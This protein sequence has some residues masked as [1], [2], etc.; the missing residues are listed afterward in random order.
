MRAHADANHLCPDAERI[1]DV[2]LLGSFPDVLVRR[3]R[4]VWLRLQSSPNLMDHNVNR[5][6]KGAVMAA[7]M[8][9]N[10]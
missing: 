6:L 1:L 10:P 9:A 2:Y 8:S 5:V 4:L 7:E 3:S